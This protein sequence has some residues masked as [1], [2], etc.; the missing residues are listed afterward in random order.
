MGV[1]ANQLFNLNKS[2]QNDKTWVKGA[3]EMLLIFG[4]RHF[5][6]KMLLN[7]KSFIYWIQVLLDFVGSDTESDLNKIQT[8][9]TSS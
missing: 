9:Q 8:A 1:D 2:G 3:G 7:K 4:K 5:K 6:Q